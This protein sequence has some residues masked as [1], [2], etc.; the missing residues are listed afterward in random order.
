M[1]DFDN[2]VKKYRDSLIR[3]ILCVFGRELCLYDQIIR[4]DGVIV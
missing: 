3:E 4:Y 1:V 2:E